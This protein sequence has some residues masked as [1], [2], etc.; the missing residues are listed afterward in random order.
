[1]QGMIVIF[2][3]LCVTSLTASS[4]LAF[5]LPELSVGA[6]TKVRVQFVNT[7]TKAQYA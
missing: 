1:M 6:A 3:L 2:E 5:L 4:L 7:G